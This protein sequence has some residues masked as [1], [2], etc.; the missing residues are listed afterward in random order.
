MDVINIWLL[1]EGCHKH[2]IVLETDRLTSVVVEQMDVMNIWMCWRQMCKQLVVAEEMNV[3]NIWMCLR[4]MCKHLDDVC[5]PLQS[6]RSPYRKWRLLPLPMVHCRV[7]STCTH[8][9]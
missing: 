2:V 7:W 1:G 6:I 8:T 5:F 9:T 3:M 4:Q